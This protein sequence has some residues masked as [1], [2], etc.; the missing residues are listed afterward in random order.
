MNVSL[1][2][3]YASIAEPIWRRNFQVNHSR[4]FRA[5]LP[6]ESNTTSALGFCRHAI[7]LSRGFTNVRPATLRV[8]KP[9][10]T[11]SVESYSVTLWFMTPIHFAF[12]ANAKRKSNRFYRNKRWGSGMTLLKPI[13]TVPLGSI[14]TFQPETDPP[15]SSGKFVNEL[16]PCPGHQTHGGTA[17][18]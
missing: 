16:P 14:W 6:E 12:A 13:L 18:R 5:S 2:M 3:L 10:T 11:P 7:L 17:P 8:A 9:R 4:L 1:N 15:C